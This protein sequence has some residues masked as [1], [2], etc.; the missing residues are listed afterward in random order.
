MN[1]RGGKRVKQRAVEGVYPEEGMGK[2][3]RNDIAPFTQL[4]LG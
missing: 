3:E 2:G 1:G 4:K